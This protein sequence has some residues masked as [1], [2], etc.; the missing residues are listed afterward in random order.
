[1]TDAATD[2]V[3]D[4]SALLFALTAKSAEA[5]HLRARLAR[6]RLHAPHLIDAEVGNALRGLERSAQLSL[7]EARE[8]MGAARVLISHRYPHVGPLVDAAWRWRHNLSFY[9]G[10]YVALAVALATPLLTA[11]VRVARV[12][13]LPCAVEVV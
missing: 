6:F 1:M 5:A 3:I 4:A 8:V 12:P 2:A 9:D 11:D 13:R 7:T 10:L